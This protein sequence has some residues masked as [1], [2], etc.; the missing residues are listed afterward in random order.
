MRKI[1]AGTLIALAAVALLAVIATNLRSTQASNETPTQTVQD[2]PGSTALAT[3]EDDAAPAPGQLAGEGDE[4]TKP[5]IGIAIDTLPPA[6]ATELGIDGG[7]VVR[8]VLDDGPSAGNL[9][10]GDVITA[11]DEHAV[12]SAAD[13]IEIVHASEPGNVLAISVLRDGIPH[14]VTVTVGTRPV[15][16]RK[17]LGSLRDPYHGFLSQIR[18]LHDSFVSL[19]LV[20]ETDEGLK[21]FTA[22]VGTL[23]DMV[24]EGATSF[25][26]V[27]K[28]GSGEKTYVIDDETTVIMGR[29]GSLD[30]LNTTDRTLVVSVVDSE[31]EKV[32][33]VLQGE[34]ALGQYL[35]RARSPGPQHRFHAPQ[36]RGCQFL[37]RFPGRFGDQLPPEIARRLEQL[38]PRLGGFRFGGEAG[39]FGG[40]L[41]DLVCDEGLT[42]E[43]P[44]GFTVRCFGSETEI[45]Q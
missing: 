38:G 15:Q 25:V 32:K 45:I 2:S 16:V 43:L 19:E 42:H 9:Q 41:R 24:A 11:I 6:E 7:A 23:K 18:G 12:T 37:G 34:I 36:R 22:L 39:E 8:R 10:V 40:L 30:G 27:P 4:E 33:L 31:G 21:T 17:H 14:G 28:D 5:F 29:T 20:L 26:L 13:V 35:D 44:E 1:V 3:A